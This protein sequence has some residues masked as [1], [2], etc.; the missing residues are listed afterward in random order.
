MR[1]LDIQNLTV[2]FSHP[3]GLIQAV[4]GIT[5]HLDPGESIDLH[6][7]AAAF[8]RAAGEDRG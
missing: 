4:R 2:S 5:L 3:D 1:L 8:A 6:G 7:C